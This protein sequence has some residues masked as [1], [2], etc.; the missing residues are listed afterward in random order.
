MIYGLIPI[1]GKG[2]RLGLPFSKEMLPQAGVL[3]YKP[4][5]S[6]VTEKMMQAGADRIIFVHG[7]FLFTVLI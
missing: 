2:T 7:S 6:H 3:F 5:V 4:I 1:G